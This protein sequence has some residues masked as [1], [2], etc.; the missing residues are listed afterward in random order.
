MRSCLGLSRFAA[1]PVPVRTSVLANEKP[2]L[3][4]GWRGS[5]CCL[6]FRND[7]LVVTRYIS[8]F[9]ALPAKIGT[10]F[11]TLD[12]GQAFNLRGVIAGCGCVVIQPLPHKTLRDA[13]LLS[14]SGLAADLLNRVLEC[15]G[16]HGA[17]L[18]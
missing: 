3:P 9:V 4:L 15:F 18:A 16:A 17:I 5:G 11:F 12:A 2:A 13:E 6:R 7:W 1:A 8:R 14:H 10:E